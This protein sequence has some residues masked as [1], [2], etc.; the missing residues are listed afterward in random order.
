[1]RSSLGKT[2]A[3]AV[4]GTAACASPGGLALVLLNSQQPDGPLCTLVAI[5]ALIP[6]L[7]IGLG[8][9]LDHR[10]EMSR[11]ARKTETTKIYAHMA[12]AFVAKGSSELEKADESATAAQSMLVLDV[13]QNANK[14]PFALPTTVARLSA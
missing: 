12:A 10:L 5:L 3:G 13:A 6:F 9:W 14:L 8:M 2:R 7:L 4:A 11:L 1:M